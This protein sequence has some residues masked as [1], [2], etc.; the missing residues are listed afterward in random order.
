MVHWTVAP[1]RSDG[2][3]TAVAPVRFKELLLRVNT[4]GSAMTHEF[5]TGWRAGR[6]GNF[7]GG[8]DGGYE[9]LAS[10]AP[11]LQTTACA[12]EDLAV[13]RSQTA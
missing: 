6:L 2:N 10:S 1:A 12:R 4:L 8:G 5:C 9:A 3:L 13:L 11:A 7:V